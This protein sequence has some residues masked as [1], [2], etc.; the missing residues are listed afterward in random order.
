MTLSGHTCF[1]VTASIDGKIYPPHHYCRMCTMALGQIACLDPFY[2]RNN[3]QQQ[4]I[5]IKCT[6][7]IQNRLCAR[8]N[9]LKLVFKR[10]LTACGENLR[11]PR[12]QPSSAIHQQRGPGQVT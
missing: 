8:K 5:V 11:K 2:K 4:F 1:I 6:M 7:A 10:Q 9:D 3:L 12:F